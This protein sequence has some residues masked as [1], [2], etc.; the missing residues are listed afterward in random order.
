MTA[1]ANSRMRM[2][3]AIKTWALPL[4]PGLRAYK[5]GHACIDTTTGNVVPGRLGATL[6]PIGMFAMDFDN[7]AGATTALVS[8]ELHEEIWAVWW[9]NDTGTP[10]LA[11]EVGQDCYVLDDQTVTFASAGASKAGRVWAVD[12]IKGVLVQSYLI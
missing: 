9:N 10:V 8:V 5:N 4:G 7:S 11:S 6:L 3:V 2:Q 1:L 12:P